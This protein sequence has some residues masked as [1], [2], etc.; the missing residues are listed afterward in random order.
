MSHDSKEYV[1]EFVYAIPDWYILGLIA[2]PDYELFD[3]DLPLETT[4][5]DPNGTYVINNTEF[6]WYQPLRG[7]QMGMCWIDSSI[8]ASNHKSMFYAARW[9]DAPV[10][11]NYM[12]HLS[13]TFTGV[14]VFVDGKQHGPLARSGKSLRTARQ[15]DDLFSQMRCLSRHGRC[16]MVTEPIG[17]A[18]CYLPRFTRSCTILTLVNSLEL[19]QP[20]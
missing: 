1:P 12:L 20:C 8:V 18:A 16:I 3:T 13:K 2:N 5:F 9:L 14:H 6:Q 10:T 15:K 7:R 19:Q 4:P 11:G 17:K